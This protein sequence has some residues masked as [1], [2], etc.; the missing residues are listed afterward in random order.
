MLAFAVRERALLRYAGLLC[1]ALVGIAVVPAIA[2]SLTGDFAFAQRSAA[3]A[4]ILAASGFFLS[5]V[6]G[7]KGLV[8]NEALVII[9]L[10][11]LVT[12]LLMSWPLMSD[13]LSWLDALFHSMSAVTTTGLTTVS[14]VEKHSTAFLVTQ[15][16]MQW[17]GGLVIIVLAVF[18]VGPGAAAKKLTASEFDDADVLAGTRIRARRTLI[19]YSILTV[20]GCLLLWLLG[21]NW[22]DA[23]LHALTAVSTGGFSTHDGSLSGL[24]NS[25]IRVAV[26]SLGLAGAVSFAWYQT[27]FL[28]TSA[29]RGVRTPIANLQLAALLGACLAVTLLLILSMAVVA[30]APLAQVLHDAPLLAVSAQTTTGFTPRD[31]ATIDDG[32][33]LILIVSMIVGGSLGSTSG[34]IKI[35]R[36]LLV[37]R[38]V[39]LAL[40]RTALPPHAVTRPTLAQHRPDE[41]DFEH[42]VAIVAMYAVVIVVSWLAFVLD[43]QDAIDSLFEVA[44]ATGTVGLSTG[45]TRPQLA[46]TLKCVLIVD[47]WMGRLDIIAVVILCRPRT[48]FGRRAE[49]P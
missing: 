15:A 25:A 43:G 5:R 10:T 1:L 42:A 26:V 6:R 24:A 9:A 21:S 11:Y 28:R 18:L 46:A 36:L 31:V 19:A 12:A 30:D 8:S 23:L 4:A 34:G 17:Y 16:W 40:L 27:W 47:M 39:Q 22:L 14:S 32:S 48:W 38:L 45:L 44:S 37:L 29:G 20:S 35:V 7:P 49:L 2:A 3:V 33:K 13:R 41:R